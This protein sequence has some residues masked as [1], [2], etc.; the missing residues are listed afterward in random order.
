M[1]NFKTKKRIQREKDEANYQMLKA[2]DDAI[3]QLKQQQR[4]IADA[5]R[6]QEIKEERYQNDL[7]KIA[8]QNRLMYG[9]LQSF[10]TISRRGGK[11][12]RKTRSK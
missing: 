10:K 12:K 11:R 9:E 4:D 2:K 7:N 6:R 8:Y 5:K 3:Y 1:D